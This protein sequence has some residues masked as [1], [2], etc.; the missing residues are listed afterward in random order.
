M[1]ATRRS[2]TSSGPIT[3]GGQKSLSF[4]QSKITKPKAEKNKSHPISTKDSLPP[5]TPID[6]GHVSSESA[7]AAQAAAELDK[8][9]PTPEELRAASI[10]DAQIAKYWRA[11]E[12]ERRTPR[13]HL[14]GVS[15]EER[16]LRLFDMSSQFG[17]GI[18]FL[19]MT[20]PCLFLFFLY[21]FDYLIKYI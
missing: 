18:G 1:P 4:N 11:R 13:V 19:Y 3:K 12:A 17:V 20:L 7:V 2:R 9:E 8:P 15:V 6:V 21:V 5:T 14:E 16:I 10:T